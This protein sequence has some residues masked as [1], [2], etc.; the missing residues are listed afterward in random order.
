M[1]E[2]TSSEG[3]ELSKEENM[4]RKC[5]V[6]GKAISQNR[7]I[8]CS[9]EC[10]RTSK[11]VKNA[12]GM[13]KKRQEEKEQRTEGRKKKDNN[14]H[15]TQVAIEARKLGMTYGEY[16]AMRDTGQLEKY[17]RRK[18][19]EMVDAN[20]SNVYRTELGDRG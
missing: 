2:Q 7:K 20:E 8:Y 5:P 10:Q 13:R 12:E 1:A 17:K 15:L 18:F 11:R 14:A 4:T 6:C 3:W 16:V 9:D 19:R